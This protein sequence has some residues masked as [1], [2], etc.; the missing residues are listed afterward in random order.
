MMKKMASIALLPLLLLLPMCS[1]GSS[2]APGSPAGPSASGKGTL[3]VMLTDKPAE[4]F[5]EV[6]VTIA[7]VRIH[8]SAGAAEGEGEWIELPV[9]AA[10]PTN[11]LLLRDGV[12]LPLCG[13]MQMPA[14]EYQQV[15]LVLA[16]NT[17]AAPENNTVLLADGT[18]Q[19]IDVP[20]GSIK[21][22]HL[23]SLAEGQTTELTLDFDASLSVK[24]R[25][26]G[27]YFMQPVVKA[28]SGK[29]AG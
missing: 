16:P 11:L 28:S 10:M 6:N 23:L 7:A 20:G 26:N 12:L 21:I 22:L 14:G 25:G 3:R 29:D 8:K 18:V 24:R 4:A 1:G 9:T 13:V 2:D 19:P 27:T 17:A 15:R 5:T